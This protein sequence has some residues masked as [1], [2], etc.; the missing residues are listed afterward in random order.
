M[1]T[2][3]WVKDKET[4]HEF[5]VPESSHLL[6]KELVV[7]VKPKIR[8]PSPYPRPQKHHAKLAGQSAEQNKS[9]SPET[10]SQATT[11]EI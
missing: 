9:V 7:P 1:P 2:Y 3:I 10:P 6:R 11:E 5:D 8:P 4:G